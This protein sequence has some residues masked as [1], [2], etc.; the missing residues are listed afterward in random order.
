MLSLVEIRA[1]LAQNETLL[2]LELQHLQADP[3]RSV[4]RLTDLMLHRTVVKDMLIAELEKQV[5]TGI[6]ISIGIVDDKLE[7]KV[8]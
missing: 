3:H 1:L 2:Q 5:E 8:G 4:R 7:R 6:N